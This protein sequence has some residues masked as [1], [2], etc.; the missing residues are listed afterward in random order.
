MEL[1]KEQELV[2]DE[3]EKVAGDGNGGQ[4]WFLTFVVGTLSAV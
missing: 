2:V 3:N 4:G 1:K